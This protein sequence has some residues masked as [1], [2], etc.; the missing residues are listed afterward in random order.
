LPVNVVASRQATSFASEPEFT[1]ITVSSPESAGIVAIRRSAS[2]IA[3]SW[4]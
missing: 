2:S 4:R 1:N 3:D